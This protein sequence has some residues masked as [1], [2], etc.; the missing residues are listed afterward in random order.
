MS[1][2]YLQ[3]LSWK[4]L[5]NF[6]NLHFAKST[7]DVVDLPGETKNTSIYLIHLHKRNNQIA[8]QVSIQNLTKQY[9]HSRKQYNLLWTLHFIK[10][11]TSL[12]A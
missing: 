3:S 9:K 1:Y 11:D 8:M 10:N 2:N 6:L 4:T 12:A 7:L 5:I